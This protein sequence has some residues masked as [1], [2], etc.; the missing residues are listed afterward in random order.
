[1]R[2]VLE[3]SVRKAGNRVRVTAQLIDAATGGH[4]WASRFD[5][6]LTDIFA[7][8]DEITQEIVAALRLN[9]TVVE[10]DR[11]A[12]MRALNVQAYEFFLRARELTLGST[13]AGNIEARSLAKAAIANEPGYAAAHALIAFTHVLD[14]VNGWGSDPEQSLRTGLE[15]AEKAVAMQQDQPLAH[16]ALGLAYLWSRQLDRARIEVQRLLALS[17]NFVE[18]WMLTAHLELYSGNPAGAIE[19]LDM[20][21]RLDPH[22]PEI[23]LQ[24]LADARF[25]LGQYAEAIAALQQRLVRNPQSETANALMASCYGHLGRLEESRQAW[26]RALQINPAFSI[27]RRRRVLPFKNP[28]DFERRVEGLRRA[29]LIA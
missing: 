2:Y 18:A 16:F 1:V 5:R 9:L 3:G 27:E 11:L 12:K 25:S 24:F 8:M 20:A 4:V 10:C 6:D 14:Y 21:V 7:V 17:P 26:E 22:Y 23:L 19:A 13:P 28:E 15:L 29:G